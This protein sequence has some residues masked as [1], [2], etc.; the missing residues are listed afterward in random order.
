MMPMERRALLQRALLL[1]GATLVPTASL[2]ALAKSG[3]APQLLSNARFRLLSA[4]A[5]TIVPVTDT[6]GALAADVP[7]NF[8]ALLR[9]W[10]S[11]IRRAEL[12]AAL[13]RIDAHAR[14]QGNKG[15]AAMTPSARNALL[16]LYDRSALAPTAPG[17]RPAALQAKP[18]ITTADPN[19]GRLKQDPVIAMMAG[20][21]VADPGY[22]K[23]KEL[24]VV[25]FYLS[26]TALTHDLEYRHAPGAW[27]P[28]TQITPQTRPSGGPSFM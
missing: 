14:E 2:E 28:S 16:T 4:V 24:I 9:N 13:E 1:A 10:A 19:Y 12:I 21:S 18:N 17:A 8:D 20:P 26:E 5:D 22:V 6:P 7:K 15:F 11:P 25:L 3:A 23:L 27:Q